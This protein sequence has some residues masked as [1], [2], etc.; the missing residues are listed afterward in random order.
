MQCWV[1]VERNWLRSKLQQCDQL[2]RSC[3]WIGLRLQSWF[4]LERICLCVL[5][6]LL[7]CCPVDW[8]RKRDWLRLQ[9]RILVERIGLRQELQRSR[10][11]N[12]RFERDRRVRLH[13]QLC[14]EWLCLRHQLRWRDRL[15]RYIER[16]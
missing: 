14:M 10:Q 8:R 7:R 1:P 12:Q 2:Q 6:G 9:L 13:C 11:L 4:R 15:Y 5:E 16:N 3:E